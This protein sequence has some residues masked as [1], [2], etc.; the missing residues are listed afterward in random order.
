MEGHWFKRQN[1]FTSFVHWF[2]IALKAP[3]RKHRAQLSMEIDEHR[4][5][6]GIDRLRPDAADVAARLPGDVR[7]VVADADR[8]VFAGSTRD[9]CAN[10]DVAIARNIEARGRAQSRVVAARGVAKEGERSISGVL[11]TIGVAYK[12]PGA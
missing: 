5:A 2:N 4:R 1:G 9:A 11:E 10:A 6:H 7:Q 12:R 3:R 8:V